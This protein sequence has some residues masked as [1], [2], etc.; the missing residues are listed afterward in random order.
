MT[1][2]ATLDAT[3]TEQD[4]TFVF[5]VENVGETAVDLRFRTG[6]VAD[7]E[8]YEAHGEGG[9]PVWRW[10]DGRM[11]TQAIQEHSLDSGAAVE[12]EF[13][14]SD[15]PSGEYVAR[16]ILAAETHAEAETSCVV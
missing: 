5:R 9:N 16:G 13:T 7:V 10:S 4:V 11:F 8:V 14:W 15:P 6:K 2:E 3:V 1:L 12:E